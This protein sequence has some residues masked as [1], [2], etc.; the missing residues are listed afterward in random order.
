MAEGF[1]QK[2]LDDA[3]AVLGV[4]PHVITTIRRG[5]LIANA[6]IDQSNVD[7]GTGDIVVLPRDPDAT[8]VALMKMLRAAYRVRV[9]VIVAD[10]V[11]HAL[12]RG[13]AGCALGVAGIH[14]VTS[15][16]GRK[17]L[18]GREMRI[19]QRA[20]ADNI[21]SAAMLLMGETD[22]R[23][24]QHPRNATSTRSGCGAPQK[25]TT[26][27]TGQTTNR[28]ADRGREG[29][30]CR[31]AERR[32]RRAR[33]H[34]RGAHPAR[35]VHLHG[36]RHGAEPTHTGLPSRGPR[37]AVTRLTPPFLSTQPHKHT[38][39]NTRRDQRRSKNCRANDRCR[40]W[41]RCRQRCSAR[42]LFSV[43]TST[44]STAPAAATTGVTTTTTASTASGSARAGH[45]RKR[46]RCTRSAR[47]SDGEARKG[48]EG[49]GAAVSR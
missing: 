4:L 37:S 1:V 17:D 43:V 45:R 5:V 41:V 11:V 32:R 33:H 46:E 31:G 34:R 24:L 15:E 27:T 30:A 28:D 25:H 9:G 18:F 3:D 22:E 39:A 49:A 40:L 21:C 8:A 6:G 35:G 12:R 48:A 14:A 38:Q 20:V 26:T 16:L 10:S 13:T 44:T 19:T 7:P 29:L 2:V 36:R 47:R 23:E 42:S